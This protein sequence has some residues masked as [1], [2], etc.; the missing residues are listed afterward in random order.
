MTQ[1]KA[2]IIASIV[3]LMVM[4]IAVFELWGNAYWKGYAPGPSFVP[5]WIIGLGG[6]VA[7]VLIIQSIRQ[8]STDEPKVRFHD[9]KQVGFVALLLC[10][11][12]VLMPWLGMLLGEAIVMLAILLIMQRRPLGPS[13]LTTAI[14]MLLI[15]GV[16][17]AWLGVDFPAGI[18]G[19]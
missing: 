1:S 12:I 17:G 7:C 2:N 11:L 10:G 4:A 14:T 15:Y 8:P 6:A 18:F 16:F 9:F 3:A 13:L 19:F 5:L